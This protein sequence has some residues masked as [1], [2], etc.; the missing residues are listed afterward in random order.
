M[1]TAFYGSASA[2][3]VGI[4]V[5]NPN[6][7]IDYYI[8]YNAK[9]GIQSGTL[10]GGNQVMVVEAGGEGKDYASS[11]LL[12][13]ITTTSSRGFTFPNLSNTVLYVDTNLSPFFASIRIE[14]SGVACAPVEPT[15][16]TNRP[17]LQPSSAPT[18]ATPPPTNWPTMLPSSAPSKATPQPTNWPA[19]LPSSAPSKATPQPTNW[20][21]LQ[22]SS[23]PTKAT[24]PPTNWPSLQPSSAPTKATPPPTNWPTMLPSSAPSK[25][26]PQPTNWPSLQPSSAPTKAT[27]PPTKWPTPPPSLQPT[28]N[29]TA[30]PSP[31]PTLTTILLWMSCV[32]H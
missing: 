1:G 12:K 8:M 14:T 28:E 11:I 16:P 10:E 9:M 23:A 3:T 18:K 31:S 5:N 25:A 26:T 4:K 22:P 6:S 20:P 15:P 7:S 13:K 21:S 30:P 24:P 32:Y 19:M 27:P 2:K 17:S 29:P